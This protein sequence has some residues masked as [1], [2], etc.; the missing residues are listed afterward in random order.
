VDRH[1]TPGLAFAR[2]TVEKFG[3]LDHPDGWVV[4][5]VGGLEVATAPDRWADLHRKAGW[6]AAWGIDARLLTPNP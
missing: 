4:N 2:D 6:A 1:R 5:P 3:A